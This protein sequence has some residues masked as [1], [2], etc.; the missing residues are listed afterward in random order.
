MADPHVRTGRPRG[1]ALDFNRGA[2]RGRALG[3]SQHYDKVYGTK[4]AEPMELFRNLRRDDV[5]EI[6]RR[7]KALDPE[8]DRK[9]LGLKLRE[10]KYARLARKRDL[11]NSRDWRAVLK[12]TRRLRVLVDRMESRWKA[13]PFP[14]RDHDETGR[15][16]RAYSG[17]EALEQCA[18]ATKIGRPA[19]GQQQDTIRDLKKH[20]LDEDEAKFFAYKL[21]FKVSSGR[22]AKRPS[23]TLRNK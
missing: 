21:G 6:Q 3:D 23:L 8:I 1:P 2:P 19:L 10:L 22:P 4:S 20:G 13:V 17:V 14:G 7:W 12:A 9:E 16:N 18:R 11:E 5:L 15:W